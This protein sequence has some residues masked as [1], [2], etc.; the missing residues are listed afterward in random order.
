MGR[1]PYGL[2]AVGVFIGAEKLFA[3]TPLNQK[4]GIGNRSRPRF[5]AT[6]SRLIA[7]FRLDWEPAPPAGGVDDGTVVKRKNY[8]V[9][10]SVGIACG[11]LLAALHLSGLATLTHTPSPRSKCL[12]VN[13]T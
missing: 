1:P 5:P 2:V 7:V 3:T 8:Y 11:F 10:E 9:G 12:P 4:S 6:D 13:D